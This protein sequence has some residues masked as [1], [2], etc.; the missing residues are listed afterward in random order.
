MKSLK[1]LGRGVLEFLEGGTDDED[2]GYYTEYDENDF[3]FD[4]EPKEEI[5]LSSTTKYER[6][7]RVKRNSNVLD[8]DNRR[9]PQEAPTTVMI[10]R[11]KEMQD[12]TIVCDHLKDNRVCIIDMKEADRL[13]AQRIAD[14]LGGVT[15]ALRGHVERIDNLTFV[16]APESVKIDSD[17]RE[18][19]ESGGWFK[20]SFRTQG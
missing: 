4:T 15:Y 2:D 8:F 9:E 7:E 3:G 11:P 16:M 17:F 1:E 19:L 20:K 5:D 12:A 10:L 13:I 6:K 18:E 14:Y